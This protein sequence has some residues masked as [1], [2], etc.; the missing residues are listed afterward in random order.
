MLENRCINNQDSF[1]NSFLFSKDNMNRLKDLM[2]DEEIAK[3][4]CLFNEGDCAD[5]LYYI[6]EGSVKLSKVTDDGK[7]LTLYYF[8]AGDLFG[9]FGDMPS[10]HQTFSA[11]A[12]CD[13]KIGVLNKE[14]VE[15]AIWQNSDLGIDFINWVSHMNRFTQLKLRDLMFFGKL[16]ALASTLI[17]IANTFGQEVGDATYIPEKF[18]NNELAS[19]IG[20]T[21]E[22][23]NRML[24]QL[25]KEDVVQYKNGKLVIL[26][27]EYLRQIC[28]CEGCPKHICRL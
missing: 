25:K 9:D 24:S 18:T 3:D 8:Q 2:I 10:L 20:S 13:C 1:H 22:T 23:V 27:I 5:S 17:R 28:H 6:K 26:D 21:R 14:D 15:L 7:D 16:G 4:S 19:M 12:T 11:I